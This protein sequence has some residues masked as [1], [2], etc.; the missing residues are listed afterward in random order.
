MSSTTT[1][2]VEIELEPIQDQADA[3]ERHNGKDEP[4]STAESERNKVAV[5]TP[6]ELP[7]P[8]TAVHTVQRWNSPRTNVPR[9]FAAFYA[10]IV[11]GMNDASYGPLIP[12]LEP[13]Y[14]I[15][16]T[17]VSLIFL[18][19]F[20]GYSLAA[21]SISTIHMHF[22][23]RGI[24]VVAPLCHL[25]SYIIISVHPPYPVLV[26]L[27]I[28]VGFG[29]GLED[30]GWCA[31]IG[32]MVNANR[33]QGFLH[34][35]Y[36][37]GATISPLIATAMVTKAGLPWYAFYY[38]MSAASF[39]ELIT[40][41]WAFWPQNATKYREENQRQS[42]DQSGRTRKAVKNRITW[43][44]AVFLLCYVGAEVSLGGWIVTFMIK[45]RS[46]SPY[47]SG[48]SSTGFWAGMTVGRASLGFLTDKFGERISVVVYLAFALALEIIF[49][50]VPKFVVS[51]IA[52]A[53]L[54][55]FFGPLF[56]AGIVMATKLLPVH[57]H[58]SGVGFA[59]AL[60]G[61]G[62]AL[63]PFAVG[64]IAE[65]KGVK[66]LQPIVLA[67]IIVL[68]VIWLSFPRV[69]KREDD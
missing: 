38:M 50:L 59:T 60:G 69:K 15:S 27:F 2:T 11:V 28:L 57:L 30:A 49:W 45:V 65:K 16:Y 4:T 39:V 5:S 13:Y 24:A 3:P 64:A 17:I 61:T 48:I 21:L 62:G 6:T 53:F 43:L 34:S 9:V 46:A 22:G 19:P 37:G 44:C 51:A 52:V 14:N 8:I 31:W 18:S 25:I 56:P 66:V 7:P 67:L 40:S 68:F 12:Y 47:A 54:G 55:F 36:A 33:I 29:N 32:N 41:S 20:L 35:F 42:D 58:V 1:A 26:V 63:L 10:F 23:Q